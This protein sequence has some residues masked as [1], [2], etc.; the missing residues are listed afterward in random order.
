[1][2][3]P[4]ANQVHETVEKHSKVFRDLML[5]FVRIHVLHHAALEPLYGAGISAEL[6]RH[7]YRLSWG[8]LYPLLHHLESEGFLTREDRVVEGKVR[9]YYEITDLGLVALGEAR[10]KAQELVREIS[11]TPKVSSTGPRRRRKAV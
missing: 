6:E 11:E 3:R 8:T 2:A 7:G 10:N 1:M 5:G 4:V 9:K